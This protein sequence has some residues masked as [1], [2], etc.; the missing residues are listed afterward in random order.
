MANKRNHRSDDSHSGTYV[1]GTLPPRGHVSE[2]IAEYFLDA[3][4]GSF[5]RV[6]SFIMIALIAV[7]TILLV[8]IFSIVEAIIPSLAEEHAGGE[9]KNDGEF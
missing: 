8:T 4:H 7:V 9:R 5:G 2:Q 6:I 1:G 3:V